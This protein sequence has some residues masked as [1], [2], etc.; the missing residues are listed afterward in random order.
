[1]QQNGLSLG[2]RFNKQHVMQSDHDRL[3]RKPPNF[4]L[5]SF[6]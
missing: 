3:I 6:T 2:H 1:M 5:M 4:P